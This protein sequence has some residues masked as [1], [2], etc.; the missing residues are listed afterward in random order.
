MVEQLNNFITLWVIIDP[1]AALPTFLG[2]TGGYDNRA[3]RKIAV[4]AVIASFFI[5]GFFIAL[6]Q[7]IIEA[8]G[9]SLRDF[10]IAGG[11][12]LFLF[13]AN[14]VTGQRQ[15]SP[16]TSSDPAKMSGL[17][18][19]PLAVP[20][21]AGPGAMLTV[22]LLTDNS[23][24]SILQQLFT[25]ATVVVVLIITLV[26]LLLADPIAR[27]IGLQGAN[28]LRR[29]MGMIVAAVAVKIVI[30]GISGWLHLPGSG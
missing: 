6:G 1:V 24:F 17:A 16:E 2:L 14:M 21:L 29:I 7:I 28:V 5:L 11:L 9:V 20:T 18:I 10:Q 19:Y 13:A 4:A 3:R 22:M 8:I 23:R 30:G 27:M 25:T 12:I 26:M 15:E